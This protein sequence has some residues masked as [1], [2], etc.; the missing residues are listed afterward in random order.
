MTEQ[1]RH[2]DGVLTGDAS[3][4]PYSASEW[5]DQERLEHGQGTIFPNYGILRGSGDGTYSTLRVQA[6]SPAS[7]NVELEIGAALVHGYLYENTAALTLA[8]GANASGNPRID[9]LILRADFIAQTIRAVVKQGT[10]A[11]SPARPTLQQDTS[12]WEIPLADIAVAN[13]FTVINQ[14]DITTRA[15]SVLDLDMG[16]LPFIYPIDYVSAG[17]YTLATDAINGSGGAV[18]IP[19]MIPAHMLVQDVNV[20]GTSGL[21]GMNLQWGLYKQDVNDG[22][23]AEKT[24][25]LVANGAASSGAVTTAR[26]TLIATPAPQYIPPGFYW[27]VIRNN[28]GSSFSIGKIAASA[29]EQNMS[30]NHATAV[31]GITQ[32]LDMVTGWTAGSSHLGASIRGR[33]FGQTTVF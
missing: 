17:N 18:A 15:R 10:P 26:W 1:S 3:L 30:M 8:V 20:Y 31:S 11:V 28:G 16:W 13:G 33:V 4:A 5:A 32:T 27:L 6:K 2:W 22:N 21:G 25:R 23:T 12:I 7:A 9:T 24:L 19:F 29:L 14:T